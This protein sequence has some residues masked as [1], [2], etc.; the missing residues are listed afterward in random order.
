MADLKM[1]IFSEIWAKIVVVFA[2][3]VPNIGRS[4][5][6]LL[7]LLFVC[8]CCCFVLFL[9]FVFVC[10]VFCFVFCFLFFVFAFCLFVCLFVCF[11]LIK[12][13]NGVCV[14]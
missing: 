2:K 3:K 7:L 12:K 6:L 4:P 14:L 5:G 9:F 13:E 11:L 10:F 1:W 8:R